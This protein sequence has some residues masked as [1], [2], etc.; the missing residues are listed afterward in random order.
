MGK[1]ATKLA[2]LHTRLPFTVAPLLLLLF[3]RVLSY[4]YVY[5]SVRA[6][7]FVWCI[8]NRTYIYIYIHIS[9]Y[10]RYSTE[11]G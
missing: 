8:I 3:T 4:V 9:L 6:R 1:H 10:Y 11:T 2:P 5:I 7:M